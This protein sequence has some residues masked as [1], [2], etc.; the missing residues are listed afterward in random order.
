MNIRSIKL[1]NFM[2]HRDTEIRL[3]SDLPY[4]FVGPNGSGKSSLVKDG[5]TY[6][7][8][9]CARAS[10][11]GD[12]LIYSGEKK[13]QVEVIL[14]VNGVSYRIVR[15]RDRGKKTDLKLFVKKD[16]LFADRTGPTATATQSDIERIL[17]FNNDL[18]VV[19]ACLEQDSRMNF[20]TLTPKQCK[21]LLMRILD[22]ERYSEYEEEARSEVTRLERIV[23]NCRVDIESNRARVA[24]Y[25]NLDS[26]LSGLYDRKKDLV[27]RMD[28]EKSRVD[29]IRVRVESEIR[30]QE[31]D[32]AKAQAKAEEL[33]LLYRSKDSQLIAAGG[34]MSS[35]GSDMLKLKQR[36]QKMAKLG[37]KCP[38]CESVIDADHI[39]AIKRE[40]SEEIEE[41]D[42]LMRL[43]EGEYNRAQSDLEAIEVEGKL[44]NLSDR[45]SA[46]NASKKNLNSIISDTSWSE[47]DK[48]LRSLDIN[49]AQLETEKKLKVDLEGDIRKSEEGIARAEG[50][51]SL[52]RVL[53]DAFGRNGI[54]AMI[55][56][57]A[58]E[59]F[60]FN[61]NAILRKLTDSDISVKIATEKNLKMSGELS[62]TLEIVIKEGLVRRPYAMYSGGEKFRIDLAIRLAMSQILAKRNSFRLETLIIDEPAFLDSKGLKSFKDAVFSLSGMFKRILIVS[63]LSE[64][65]DDSYNRFNVVRLSK[66]SG[67]GSIVAC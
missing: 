62:D 57:N 64:L 18:F 31:E 59:E 19:S 13:C 26:E 5:V 50:D 8:F 32:L 41:N 49:I 67:Y 56:S 35:V 52:Y 3:D 66:K 40:I 48:S 4:L 28:A 25:A 22:I 21:E 23:E 53:R 46:L 10:G 43:A 44:L 14:D 42:K 33:R 29:A 60:E 37:D 17:G 58:V 20:S 45:A 7:L 61:I 63:H 6:A 51:L 30:S 36:M 1:H 2:S 16:G 47:M 65:V 34:H 38:T 9:G 15:A 39:V 24:K 12:D 27:A 11:A 54:P 55:I